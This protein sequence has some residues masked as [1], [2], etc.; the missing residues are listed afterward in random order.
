MAAASASERF[1]QGLVRHPWLTLLPMAVILVLSLVAFKD[2]AKDT[3]SDA[4]LSPDNPALVYRDLIRERF[5]LSDPLLVALVASGPEGIYRADILQSVVALTEALKTVPNVDADRVISLSTESLI[6]GTESSIEVQPILDLM[7]GDSIPDNDAGAAAVRAAVEDFPLFLGSL[8]ARGG[9]ATLLVVQL[10]DEQR[11]ENTYSDIIALL[12][13]YPLPPGV[14][15]HVAGEGAIAGYLGSYIDADARRL[16]PLAG[17]VILGMIA[18][19]FRR[20]LPS[21]LALVIILASVAI[22]LGAMAA[23]DIPFYVITNGLPVILIGISVADTIHI[24]SHYFHL[25]AAVP[26]RPREELVVETMA[27]M[28]VPVTLTSLTTVAGFLGLY[29]AADMPPFRYF[30]LFAALGVTAAWLYSIVVLPPLMTLLKLQVHPRFIRADDG[31]D[32][33]GR[34]ILGSGLLTRRRP[35]LLAMAALIAVAGGWAGSQLVV[36]DDRIHLFHPEEPIA[37]AD[38]AINRHFNGTNTLDIVIETAEPEGVFEPAVLSRME[39]LQTYAETLPHVTGSSSIVDYLKQMNRVLNDN[40]PAAYALPDSRDLVAQ[41]FLLYSLSADPAD[42]EQEVDYDYRTA[43]V[44]LTMNNGGYVQIAQ[45]VEA[46]QAYLAR[47]FSGEVNATL[48]GRV[49]LNYHWVHSIGDSHLA[50]LLMALLLVWAVAS[51]SYRSA[52]AGVYTLVPVVLAVLLVYGFMVASGMTLGVGTS[53]FAAVAIGLG[54]D[55]SIHTISRLQILYSVTGGEEERMVA[56]F[57]TTTGRALL[58]NVMT[59]AVGF[60]VLIF[61]QISQLSDFGSIV[62]LSMAVSFVASVTLLPALIL[63]LRPAFVCGALPGNRAARRKSL[64]RVVAQVAVVLA[65]AAIWLASSVHAHASEERLASG[66]LSADD[67]VARVNAV[68]QGEQVTRDLLFRTV[69]RQGR[70]RERQTVSYRRYFGD[71]RRLVLFFT[72]PA[73]IRDTAVLTWDYADP[74]RADDQWLYL[75]ALRKVRRIPASDRGDYFLGTDFSF[76]DMKLDGRLSADDYVYTLGAT[77]SEDTLVLEGLPRSEALAQEL[78]YSRTLT[79]VETGNWMITKVDF[80]DPRGGHLKTLDVEDIRDV[81]GIPTRHRLVM[82]N[83]QTGHRTELEFEKVDYR[84]PVDE[85]VFTQQALQRG[86]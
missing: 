3:R 23:M 68:P 35:L 12:D 62:M 52:L 46:L 56:R 61:S 44:R 26:Q 78:G 29:F 27:G 48:S 5:A 67:V 2:L 39:A 22:A 34:L 28:W 8:V 64:V 65:L 53:M 19:A 45:V 21:L 31:R 14:V 24:C 76:E 51:L 10:L 32:W 20:F 6:T 41:Y 60:G 16:N 1:F 7:P 72:A 17:F 40:D 38:R 25:Q 81:D 79:V 58:F 70:S 85:R 77:E 9:E 80:W 71:E 13:D 57:L 49:A 63:A 75:P 69:D 55:F 82:Q 83:H 30:G 86:R 42:F 33:L 54:V 15:A 18:L 11:S 36:D 59:V 66:Q 47:E 84:T 37:R 4:F 74:A 43:N 50:G 73:N